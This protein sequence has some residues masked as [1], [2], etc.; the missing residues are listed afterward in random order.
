[1]GL[2]AVALLKGDFNDVDVVSGI[3]TLVS[4]TWPRIDPLVLKRKCYS[5]TISPT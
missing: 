4:L 1:M 3:A 5:C 2:T